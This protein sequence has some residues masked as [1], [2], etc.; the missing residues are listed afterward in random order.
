MIARLGALA[1]F[2][3]DG[4]DMIPQPPPW[5]VETA[6]PDRTVLLVVGLA[7]VMSLIVGFTAGHLTAEP[8]CEATESALKQCVDS[9]FMNN[10]AMDAPHPKA[11]AEE[12][13]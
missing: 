5:I 1:L 6:K 7:I 12:W 11:K 8:E 4:D 10:D 9:N 13:I 2:R 3:L